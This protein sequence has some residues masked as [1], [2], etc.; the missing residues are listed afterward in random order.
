MIALALEKNRKHRSGYTATDDE[1]NRRVHF[2]VYKYLE[3]IVFV[4][5]VPMLLSD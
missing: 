3:V 1:N 4:K 5:R 2:E